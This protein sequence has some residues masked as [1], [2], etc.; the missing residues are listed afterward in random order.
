MTPVATF[1]K[2]G[3][4]KRNNDPK[5]GKIFLGLGGKILTRGSK[6]SLLVGQKPKILGL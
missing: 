5:V 6:N 3:C 1:D 2:P 4:A